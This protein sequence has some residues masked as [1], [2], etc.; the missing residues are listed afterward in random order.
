MALDDK[1]LVPNSCLTAA[2]GAL[3]FDRALQVVMQDMLAVVVDAECKV[4]IYISEN[5]ESNI[6]VQ[7]HLEKFRM[8]DILIDD[9]NQIKL[10]D[11][12]TIKTFYNQ[13][14]SVYSDEE[15]SHVQR[16]I[17]TLIQTA[18]SRKVSDIHININAANT[19]IQFR[20]F[21]RLHHYKEDLRNNG[22]DLLQTMYNFMTDVADPMFKSTEPQ[23]AVINNPAFLTKSLNGVRVNIVPTT[24]GWKACLR[25]LYQTTR[26]DVNS[27]EQL[28]YNQRLLN[29]IRKVTAKS[30]GILVIS[31]PTN[32]GK[33]TTLKVLLEEVAKKNGC[34]EDG[35]GCEINIMT[36][37][38]PSE[39]KILGAVQL[40]VTGGETD[41]ERNLQYHSYLKSL[42]R[43]DPDV[44]MIG[45]IR[46]IISAKAAIKNAMSGHLC[47]TTIHTNDAFTIIDR[48]IE[49]GVDPANVLN[50]GIVSG[51]LAQRLVPLLCTHCSITLESA[52]SEYNP[53]RLER[54][55]DIFDNDL[56]GIRIRNPGGCLHCEGLGI[57][58]VTVVAEMIPTD[59]KFMKLRQQG[60][61]DEAYL[62]WRKELHGQTLM[63]HGLEK[64][65]AGSCDPKDVE[66]ELE[67]LFIENLQQLEAIA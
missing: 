4:D 17:V 53:A 30:S 52:I 11:M 1:Y 64:I 59:K 19:V 58:G 22:Y 13:S 67:E 12:K 8:M 26:G 43:Q 23:D 5:H 62:Y 6:Q 61:M 45:E 28:G 10:C 24:E 21:K 37:E 27:L 39:Y 16:N 36:V 32:S 49:I 66:A 29:D 34:Q 44:L 56:S 25:L 55:R 57:S 38:D 41:E 60:K 54:L 18:A 48:L 14:A 2:G 35:T 42:L 33:S 46:D 7:N 50:S 65:K 31:G 20:K 51:L 47:F 63:E 3:E 15:S 9:V 40:A